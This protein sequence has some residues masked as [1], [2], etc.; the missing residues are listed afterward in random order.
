MKSLL[1]VMLLFGAFLAAPSDAAVVFEG[2]TA[3][4]GA[5][6]FLETRFS[7]FFYANSG[8]NANAVLTNGDPVM[9][10]TASIYGP[11]PGPFAGKA[12]NCRACHL[13][14]EH[15][16][17]G[18]RTY[19]DFAPRSPIPDNGDGRTHAPR[20]AIDLVNSLMP[21]STPLF[22]HSDGQF[23]DVQ[24][25]VIT[26]FTGRNFGWH[27]SEYATAISHIAKIVR[28]DDGSG[29]LAQQYGGWTYAEALASG[30]QI[31]AAYRI[32]PGFVITNVGITN[33]A[34]PNYVS[35]ERIVHGVAALVQAYMGTLFLS[36]DPDDLFDGSPYDV[37]LIKN[38]LPRGPAV[39]ETRIEY[40]RRLLRQISNLANP[41]WVT[42]PADGHMV[43]HNQRFQFGPTELA[44]LKIFFAED[45]PPRSIAIPGRTG[46][47]IACHA[48]PDFTD[49]LFHN[50]G[51]AQD[52]YDAIHGPG[53]FMALS[54]PELSERQTNYDAFLPPTPLH[55]NALGTFI[56]PP[57]L[58][59]PG[60]VDLGLWNVFA[61][62]DFPNPQPALQQILP[63][64]LPTLPPQIT[65]ARSV[66]SNFAFSGTNGT[67][68]WTYYVLASTNLTL[69]AASWTI[70]ST[71]SFDNA[72]NFSCTRS[73][74]PNALEFYRVSAAPPSAA[75]ALPRTLAL[76]KTPDLRDLASSE[77][78]MHTGRINT[79]QGVITFYQTVAVQ[80]RAGAIRNADPKLKEI[81]LD[82]ESVAPLVAFLRAL[83][84]DYEDIPC[85]CE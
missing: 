11:L 9:D 57:T 16:Q 71:N 83:N 80:A 82:S 51:A 7:R 4:V 27:P 17:T 52:E 26:T 50:T 75:Q 46:N 59:A 32:A 23:S 58:G 44:G 53:S 77:P 56:T 19:A 67:P 73:M 35:D 85:P 24:D 41:Q 34:D 5:R 6:F 25:L 63:L 38:G 64:L 65:T 8:G 29:G 3:N 54:V 21:H 81:S 40:G 79:L 10:V 78:Y 31:Q 42:D 37:F 13:V 33:P 60:H 76:F 15:L 70:V 12:M 39:N 18:N 48:P 28:E 20:N 14:E 43:M 66:G 55:P 84:E 62:P 2:G 74:L 36:L 68:G 72:G 61:N 69:P 49:F 47:C 1:M 45:D 30:S 22:L